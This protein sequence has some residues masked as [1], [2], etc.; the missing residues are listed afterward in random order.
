[1]NSQTLDGLL[2]IELPITVRLGSAQMSLGDVIG[3]NAGSLV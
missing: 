2:D 3:L 1:M